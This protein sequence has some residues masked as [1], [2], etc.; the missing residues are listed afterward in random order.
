MDAG[1]YQIM[2][3]SDE[4][5]NFS[6]NGTFNNDVRVIKVDKNT[7][8]ILPG[9][10][11]SPSISYDVYSGKK[12]VAR[13]YLD[14]TH[15]YVVTAATFMYINGH[16]DIPVNIKIVPFK[17][18]KDIA[19]GLDRVIGRNNEFT[20]PD[21]DVLYDCPILI[22]N[23]QELPS[24]EINGILHRFLA[25]NPGIFNHE[26]LISSLEKTVRAAIN[27]IGDIPYSNYTFIGIGPGYGGIE[28]LNSNQKLIFTSW[29][30]N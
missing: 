7:W 15:G 13:N 25:Y 6:A 21:F 8:S 19:T 14:A 10:N 2:E 27:I 1:N 26:Q 28:D 23:L 20:A 24:F 30:G 5:R 29:C 18:W 16:L 22:G 11:T 9:K 3:Y 17:G 12:F 4:E